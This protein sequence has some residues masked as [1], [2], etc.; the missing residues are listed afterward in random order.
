[1]VS[2]EHEEA[3]ERRIFAREDPDRAGSQRCSFRKTY[4]ME[5]HPLS[6]VVVDGHVP[7]FD[8]LTDVLQVVGHKHLSIFLYV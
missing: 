4:W 1:M 8:D 3:R 6:P 7:P 5:V 2:A